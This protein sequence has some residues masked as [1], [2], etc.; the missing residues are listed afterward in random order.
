MAIKY[1]LPLLVA[2]LIISSIPIDAKDISSTK[3]VLSKTVYV[4]DDADPGW[5]DETHVKTINDGIN[6][7]IDGDTIFVYNGTY[8]EKINITKSIKLIGEN[9]YST[10]I[11]GRY[12]IPDEHCEFGASIIRIF[13]TDNV[14]V[15]GF[16]IQE[17]ITDT[18]MVDAGLRI[19]N[20]SYDTISDNIFRNIMDAGI[21]LGGCNNIVSE[22]TIVDSGQ[23]MW[24][25]GGYD[26]HHTNS[27]IKNNTITNID[28]EG[29]LIWCGYDNTIIN[30]NI[31][32]AYQGFVI[33]ESCNN[34]IKRNN[35]AH[36]TE[37]MF[38][39]LSKRNKFY[40]NNFIDSGYAGHVEYKGYSFFNKWKNNY[41]DNQII[42]GLP[43]ILVGRFGVLPIP[44]F[45][46]DWHP[47]KKP[48]VIN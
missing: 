48:Y 24:I 46:F 36:N 11:D 35:I 26:A 41:W 10:I 7:T 37:G 23:G 18:W 25:S 31:T 33:L 20:S 3:S 45:H 8:Y 28:A 21:L 19:G 43:K 32:H 1:I 47:A 40:E 13:K 15:S 5:Y 29:I 2:T 16:T 4:D 30:N 38:L 12:I 6:K 34:L 44:W 39:S 22:N 14:T 27:I 17:V 42:H 9:K